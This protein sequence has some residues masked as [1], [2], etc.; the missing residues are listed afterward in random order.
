MPNFILI[1]HKRAEIESRE[2]NRELGR[3]NGYYITV[4]LT[5]DQRSPISIWFEP[6]RQAA[7]Y[8]NRVQIGSSVRLEF[9][10]QAEPDRH[11][12]TQTK[13]AVKI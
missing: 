13:A 3:K 2:V 9:C 8:K 5:F 10:S 11:T 1:G 7:I 4:T 12:D 6:L